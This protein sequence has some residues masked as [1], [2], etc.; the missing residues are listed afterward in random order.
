MNRQVSTW[1]IEGRSII[2]IPTMGCLHKGHI[3]LIKLAKKKAGNDGK[4][5]V[6]LFVNPHQFAPNEDFDQYPRS[7]SNDLSICQK[8]NVDVIFLPSVSEIYPSTHGL[9]FSTYVSENALSLLMEGQSRP[10]HFRGV[11]TILIILFHIIKP[12]HSVFGEKDFQQVAIVKKMIS[13]LHI[14]VKMIIGKTI[15]EAD[16]L[17]LSSR[18]SYLTTH[19]RPFANLLFRCIRVSR[20]RV[21]EASHPVSALSLKHD[22]LKMIDE[23]PEAKLDYLEF[24][25]PISLKPISQVSR[26]DRIGLAIT[27]GKTRLIDNGQM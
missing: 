13:D 4:V 8:L 11:T 17:A 20:K 21:R 5:V 1:Q 3:H 10:D 14:P 2:L 19:Q 26:K 12:T 16:G 22:L 27:F 24:F 9:P 25:D 7:E 23:T 18:N 15:R 6:S